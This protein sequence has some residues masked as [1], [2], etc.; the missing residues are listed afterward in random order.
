MVIFLFYMQYIIYLKKSIYEL[1]N[2]LCE[3]R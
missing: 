1:T 2:L 3:Y